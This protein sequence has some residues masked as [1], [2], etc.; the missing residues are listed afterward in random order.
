MEEKIVE[1]GRKEH[2][3]GEIRR[4]KKLGGKE[5]IKQREKLGEEKREMG[6]KELRRSE[7]SREKRNQRITGEI[8]R[9]DHQIGERKWRNEEKQ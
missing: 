8:R 1:V 9:K 6:R 7:M 5:L 4:K 3:L 2:Q